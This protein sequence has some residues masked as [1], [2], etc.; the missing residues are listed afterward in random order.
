MENEG[1]LLRRMEST[2]PS[3]IM[4]GS[5]AWPMVTMLFL[6][7]LGR[8]IRRNRKPPTLA[9]RTLASLLHWNG[10]ALPGRRP[11]PPA[12]PSCQIRP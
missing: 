3:G 9:G 2:Q 12:G 5:M 1:S 4:A 8:A 7:G 11:W 6:S 10:L